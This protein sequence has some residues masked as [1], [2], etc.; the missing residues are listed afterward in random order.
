MLTSLFSYIYFTPTYVN[1]LQIFA[2]CRIDDLSW[3]TK[4]LDLESSALMSREWERRKFIFVLQYAGTNVVLSYIIIRMSKYDLTKN[5]IIL[6]SSALV[7]F[8]LAFR[9][10]FALIYIIRYYIQKSCKKLKI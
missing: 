7:V 3:G 10:I 2:F 9:L 5:I 6:T 1:I 8:L 4:G